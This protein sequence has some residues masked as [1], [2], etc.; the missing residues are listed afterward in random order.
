MHGL[1]GKAGITGT[2][3]RKEPWRCIEVAT[4]GKA[5]QVINIMDALEESMQAKGRAKV[6][7]AVRRR[8]GKPEKEEVARP[9]ASRP[10]PSLR[11]T[12]H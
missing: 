1:I 2:H 6:R 12:A 8:M 7:D 9:R 5:P 3:S 4:E 11:W 10:R